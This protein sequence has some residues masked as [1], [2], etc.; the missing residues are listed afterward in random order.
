MCINKH[1]SCFDVV[2]PSASLWYNAYSIKFTH[3]KCVD[4]FQ[5]LLDSKILLG[6]QVEMFGVCNPE[7]H[8]Y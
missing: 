2:K 7:K 5:S 3:S 6:E 8:L 4:G 1:D